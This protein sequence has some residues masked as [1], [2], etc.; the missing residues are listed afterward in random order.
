[1]P[2]YLGFQVRQLGIA[3]LDVAVCCLEVEA[4]AVQLLRQGLL[5]SQSGAAVNQL[6]VSISPE[7]TGVVNMHSAVPLPCDIMET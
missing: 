4:Q 5:Y 3:Q 1:M 6:N 2:L 7:G